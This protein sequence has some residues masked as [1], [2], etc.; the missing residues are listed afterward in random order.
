MK[1]R[2]TAA[3]LAGTLLVSACGQ[4]AN[5]AE[6]QEVRFVPGQGSLEELGKAE[7]SLAVK[8]VR[9]LSEKM[10]VPV[11]DIE[12]DTIRAVNWR[13]SSI[14]CPKPGQ[15]YGQVITPGYKVTLRIG[16]QF[17]F[18]HAA[19]NN[20]FVCE[21]A[22]KT[23]FSAV[24]NQRQLVWGKQMIWARKDLASR[25]GLA[26]DQVI[27]RS[28]QAREFEDGSLDCPEPGK[29]YQT[30]KR[31]GYVLTLTAAGREYHYHTDLETTIL[32]PPIT[33]D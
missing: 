29:T 13:D 11:K 27:V 12:L 30:G 32:C 1:S 3:V 15:A 5:E 7:R 18:V 33:V 19:G 6:A 17:H 26:E 21:S 8:A 25:L 31:D 24:D 2:T 22:G 28:S 14:G 16:N 20:V 4:G 23:N 10:D 9:A